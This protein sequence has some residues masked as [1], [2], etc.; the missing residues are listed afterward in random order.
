MFPTSRGT[1]ISK[2]TAE[3][4]IRAARADW[5]KADASKDAPNV[6]WVTFHTFRRHVATV[7]ENKVS[8]QAATQQLGHSDSVVTEH[9]YI[10]KPKHGPDVVDVLNETLFELAGGK[11]MAK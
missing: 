5:L 1:H 9:H 2:S 6:D 8:L 11:L 4:W 7:L 3:R 10:A